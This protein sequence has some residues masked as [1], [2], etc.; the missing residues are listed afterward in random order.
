MTLTNLLLTVKNNV[1]L[2]WSLRSI[3]PLSP[4]DTWRLWVTWRG[5][6]PGCRRTTYLDGKKPMRPKHFPRHQSTSEVSITV[7]LYPALQNKFHQIGII[8]CRRACTLT[9]DRVRRG[10]VTWSCKAPRTG[11]WAADGAASATHDHKHKWMEIAVR[12]LNNG[13]RVRPR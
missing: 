9:W 1:D 8:S 4:S 3:S 6:S 12:A 11:S 2:T 5:R 7:T 10:G 13:A